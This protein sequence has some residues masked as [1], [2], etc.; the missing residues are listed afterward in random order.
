MISSIS[1]PQF[2]LHHSLRGTLSQGI[3]NRVSF[4]SI[5]R[6]IN[7]EVLDNFDSGGGSGGNTQLNPNLEEE[8]NSILVI[9][10]M[11]EDDDENNNEYP[12][13]DAST[14]RQQGVLLDEEWWLISVIASRTPES[15]TNQ[16]TELLPSFFEAMGEKDTGDDDNDDDSPS[17]KTKLWKPSQ[18]W[19][20][21]KSGKNPWVEP[22]V[23][24]NRWR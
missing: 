1:I 23:H 2:Q 17:S 13:I 24:D 15:I 3:I 10:C 11:N 5:L 9:S 18:S 4:Y 6:D 16:S 21:A 12:N 14:T 7:Q 8:Q 19:W 22:V 20:D